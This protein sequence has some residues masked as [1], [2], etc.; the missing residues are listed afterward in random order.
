MLQFHSDHVQGTDEWQEARL[1]RITASRIYDVIARTAKGGYTAKRDDYMYQLAAERM[2]GIKQDGVTT[3]DMQR[4]I[5]M[6]PYAKEFYAE[7]YGVKLTDAPF[8]LHREMTFSGASPDAIANDSY[9]VEFKNPRT[10]TF[11]K[12]RQAGVPPENYLAQCMW[13]MACLQADRCDLVF[14]DDRIIDPTKQMFV[15][16]IARDDDVIANMEHEVRL[17][18]EAIEAIVNK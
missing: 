5:E 9:L 17:F 11:L 14:Y 15:F 13:Q 6:E 8:I 3:F 18:N 4:G 1:G 12:T 2:T 16:C 7:Y 10:T